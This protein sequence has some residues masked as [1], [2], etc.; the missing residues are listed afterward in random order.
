MAR[1]RGAAAALTAALSSPALVAA[2]SV[3]ALGYYSTVFV[4]LDHWLGLGTTAGAAHAA[5]FSL[6]VAAC[7]FSFLCAAAADPGSVPAAFSP[8]A[9]DPQGLKSRYCDKCCMYKPA[10]THHCK[11][12]KR[13]VLK[14]DHHCVWINNCVGYANYKP[15]IICVLNATIGSLYASVIFVRDLLQTEH[16]FHILYVKIIHIL[17][18]VILFSL[19]LTIGSLLCWHIYLMCHNMTTIE[20]ER[21]GLQRRVDRTTVTALIKARGR[22]FK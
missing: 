13:C 7:L 16:N 10:R 15:F 4:F 6:I 5:A 19:C 20:L 11:V 17:A 1:R 9:E 14:M 22:I 8:D 12:C 18:G 3:M 2:V 21:S